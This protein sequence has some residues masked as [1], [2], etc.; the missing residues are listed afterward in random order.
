MARTFTRFLI[1]LAAMAAAACSIDVRGEEVVVREERRFAVGADVDLAVSTFD[2]ALE[3]RSWDRPEVL[4]EIERRGPSGADAQALEVRTEQQ[5]NRLIVDAPRPN[6]G[7]DEGVIHLGGFR[8]PSVSLRITAPARLMLDA[9]TGDGAIAVRDLTGRITLHTADGAVNAERLA[10]AV[11]VD[12]GDGAVVVRELR[13][14][15]ELHTGDGAVDVSGRLDALRIVTGDGA[16]RLAAQD[17]SSMTNEWTVES[18]D[19]AITVRLPDPFDAQIDAF[20]GDGRIT[21]EGVATATPSNDSDGPAQL[22]TALGKGGHV[23]RLRTGDG[24]VTVNR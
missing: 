20:S 18:G 10:G 4:V 7:A 15:L 11:L 5:G 9:R 23:L 13:G 3:V 6:R 21:V 16:I 22:R 1:G 24:P 2:G 14:S 12:S 19:G 8:S 17:G